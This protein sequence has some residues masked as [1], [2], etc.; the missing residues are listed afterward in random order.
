MLPMRT[1]NQ[2]FLRALRVELDFV[3][4]GGYRPLARAPWRAQAA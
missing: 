3:E 1:D 2:S 4:S